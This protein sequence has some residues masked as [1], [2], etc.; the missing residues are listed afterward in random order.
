MRKG[1]PRT[2]E[3]L[4]EWVEARIKFLKSNFL[5]LTDQTSFPMEANVELGFLSSALEWVERTA[6]SEEDRHT[7]LM[8]FYE[9][10]F[11]LLKD[12]LMAQHQSNWLNIRRDKNA[13]EDK[14]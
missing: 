7:K 14:S 8:Y 9:N 6:E 1:D 13:E 11:P 4:V 12:I 3:E 2:S 10:V 5:L